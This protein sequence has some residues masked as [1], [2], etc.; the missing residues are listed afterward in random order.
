MHNPKEHQRADTPVIVYVID[1][2]KLAI[3]KG[4]LDGVRKGQ[5]YVVY[6]LSESTIQDPI[7]KKDLGQLEIVRGTGVVVHVQGSMSTIRSLEKDLTKHKLIRRPH[8][9]LAALYGPEE[10]T[11]TGP[12]EFLPFDSPEVGDFARPI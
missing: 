2:L 6:G 4:S 1:D 11:I 10:E 12:D 9:G 5:K 3:N 7:T 8:I